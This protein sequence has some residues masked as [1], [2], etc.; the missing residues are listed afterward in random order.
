M[1]SARET[2]G[3]LALKVAISQVEWA[4]KVAVSIPAFAI[5]FFNHLPKMAAVTGRYGFRT[6]RNKGFLPPDPY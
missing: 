5:M 1:I 3:A 2:P 6:D 4:E